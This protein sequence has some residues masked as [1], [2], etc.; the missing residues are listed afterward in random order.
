MSFH[1]KFCKYLI[2]MITVV[3]KLNKST[4]KNVRLFTNYFARRAIKWRRQNDKRQD[5]SAVKKQSLG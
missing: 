4:G 2:L 5:I 1:S 3:R